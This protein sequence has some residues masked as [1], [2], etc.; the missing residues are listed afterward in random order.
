MASVVPKGGMDNV[1]MNMI[2]E[3][4]LLRNIHVLS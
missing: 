2:T 3:H 1:A 4:A